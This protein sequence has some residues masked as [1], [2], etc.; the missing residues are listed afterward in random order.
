MNSRKER[1]RKPLDRVLAE[2]APDRI[3]ELERRVAQLEREVD[4]LKG[5]SGSPIFDNSESSPGKRRPGPKGKIGDPELFRYRDGLINWLEPFWPWM[6]DRLDVAR[7]AGEIGAI[8]E[9]IAN[10]PE[11]RRD[12]ELRLLQNAA[13][14][15]EFLSDERFGKSLPKATGTDALTLPWRNERRIRAANQLP[16]RRIANAMAGVPDIAWRTS[17]DRCSE[18]PS[19]TELAVNLDLHYR[20]RF[21]IRPDPERDLTGTF[22]PLPKRPQPRVAPSVLDAGVHHSTVGPSGVESGNIAIAPARAR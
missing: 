20:E 21:G 7:T 1:S 15:F 14:L 10:V 5:F 3:A 17:L 13:A 22:S 16:V 9:A 6:V 19:P 12:W 4:L 8:L 2:R 11:L 18:Q